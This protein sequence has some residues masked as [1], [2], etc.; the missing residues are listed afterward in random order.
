MKNHFNIA[1][2]VINGEE[3]PTV[4]ARELWKALH[5]RRANARYVVIR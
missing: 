4:N 5:V 1:N 3:Q 2:A